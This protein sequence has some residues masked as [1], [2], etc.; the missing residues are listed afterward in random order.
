MGSRYRTLIHLGADYKTICISAA[1][2]I[3]WF[4][5]LPVGMA[6]ISSLFGTTSLFTEMLPKS[7]EGNIPM[8]FGIAGGVTVV[9]VVIEWCYIKMIQK[10]SHSMILKM[11][12]VNREE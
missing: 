7:L 12:D 6:V 3:R 8:I 11:I 5:V 10:H 9:M 1:R 4:F 2:Q